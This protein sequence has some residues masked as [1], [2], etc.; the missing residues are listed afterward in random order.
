MIHKV[1]LSLL[2]SEI[3]NEALWQ[4]RA[5]KKCRLQVS[6]VKEFRIIRRSIDARKRQ[7]LFRLQIEV[8]QGES[9]RPKPLLR[10][11]LKQVKGERKVCDG[12]IRI[13]AN[14]NSL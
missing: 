6:Q 7:V 3:E 1:E 8:Y 5:A 9:F 4:K 10:N 2:P 12:I 11:N 13:R 14:S